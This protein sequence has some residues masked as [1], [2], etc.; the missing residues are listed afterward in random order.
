MAN[1]VDKVLQDLFAARRV[2]YFGMKLQAVKFPL[3][4][5]NCRE[6]GTLGL[7]GGDETFW[8]RS[9]F[10]AV[11][12]PDVE[13]MAEAIEQL[14]AVGDVEHSRAVFAPTGENDLTPEMMRHLHQAVTNS[15]DRNA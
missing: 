5:F 10:V 15:K 3:S 12:V 7:A 6:I 8:Q 2:S 4:I 13:L 14:R 1:V 9:Y 11:A